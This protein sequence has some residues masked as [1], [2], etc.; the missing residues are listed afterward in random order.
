MIILIKGALT[1]PFQDK[2]PLPK[3]FRESRFKGCPKLPLQHFL[4]SIKSLCLLLP[5]L[6]EHFILPLGPRHLL[7]L[8][9]LRLP[10]LVLRFGNVDRNASLSIL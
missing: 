3:N 10:K 8:C 5:S 9:P 2:V 7:M 6:R 4:V 1:K